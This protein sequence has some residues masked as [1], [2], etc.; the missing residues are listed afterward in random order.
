M[1]RWFV[2]SLFSLQFL[3]FVLIAQSKP[4]C[5]SQFNCSSSTG[6]NYAECIKNCGLN[7]TYTPMCNQACAKV[8][9]QQGKNPNY[10]QVASLPLG[11]CKP[12]HFVFQGGNWAKCI[13]NCKNAGCSRGRGS[14]SRCGAW[15]RAFDFD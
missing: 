3:S 15:C 5:S 12:F 14:S 9:A 10:Q 7:S 8:F 2:K 1:K 6:S 11:S 13:K 4:V